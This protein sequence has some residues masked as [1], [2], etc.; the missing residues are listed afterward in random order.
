V[1]FP[2]LRLYVPHSQN[3]DVM[4]H[5]SQNLLQVGLDGVDGVVDAE[6]LI[7]PVCGVGILRTP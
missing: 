7:V 2:A 6:Y 4:V 3:V 5:L 1:D